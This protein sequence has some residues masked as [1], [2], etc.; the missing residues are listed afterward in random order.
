LARQNRSITN[1]TG[2]ILA[3]VPQSFVGSTFDE[4]RGRMERQAA[5]ALEE[6]ERKGRE[7]AETFAWLAAERDR[8][9]S[10]V[11]DSTKPEAERDAAEKKL[12]QMAGWNP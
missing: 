12:R 3:T 5:L 10:I 2:L 4:F 1:P 8:Y 6:K 11:N 7:E 9:E